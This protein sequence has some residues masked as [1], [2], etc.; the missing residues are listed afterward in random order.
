MLALAHSRPPL[1]LPPSLPFPSFLVHGVRH[2]RGQATPTFPCPS[3][4]WRGPCKCWGMQHTLPLP[5][6]ERIFCGAT[7]QKAPCSYTKEGVPTRILLRKEVL[8][9]ASPLPAIVCCCHCSLGWEDW[10]S[11]RGSS[12][13]LGEPRLLLS[14]HRAASRTDQRPAPSRQHSTVQSDALYRTVQTAAQ[15]TPVWHTQNSTL[16]YGNVQP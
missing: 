4:A 7:V 2:V 13:C 11:M 6:D 3:L 16:D 1:S 10:H 14:H 12:P 9:C 15:C 8:L 5:R